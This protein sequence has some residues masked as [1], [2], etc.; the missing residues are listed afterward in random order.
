MSKIKETFYIYGLLLDLA[1][2]MNVHKVAYFK[3]SITYYLLNKFEH[4]RVPRL[5][6]N[7]HLPN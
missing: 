3:G 7:C 2:S 5:S 1:V 6:F 4:F